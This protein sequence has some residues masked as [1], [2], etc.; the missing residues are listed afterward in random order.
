MT[1]DWDSRILLTILN[2]FFCND[3][4]DQDKCV[5]STSGTYYC[6]LDGEVRIIIG[7]SF[8]HHYYDYSLLLL[9]LL[10]LIL[11]NI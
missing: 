8:E 9:L 11:Y 2:K 6:P 4:L 1:D 3:I 10:L 5:F 7:K